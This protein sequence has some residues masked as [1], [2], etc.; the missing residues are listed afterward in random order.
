MQID[1]FQIM[2]KVIFTHFITEHII[3][4]V[5]VDEKEKK[6]IILLCLELTRFSNFRFTALFVVV[7]LD[8]YIFRKPLSV[9]LRQTRTNFV[10]QL[11]RGQ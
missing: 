4:A 2:F 3:N 6:F 9:K 1:D 11:I 7:G 10:R 8:I 5:F